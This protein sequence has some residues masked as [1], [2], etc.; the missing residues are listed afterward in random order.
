MCEDQNT[1]KRLI[2]HWLNF[3]IWSITYTSDKPETINSVSRENI[4]HYGQHLKSEFENGKFTRTNT[5]ASYLSGMNSVMELIHGD[6]W[7]KISLLKDCGSESIS[8]IP[9]K[10]PK[11]DKK[12]FP[13]TESLAGYLLGNGLSAPRMHLT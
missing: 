3:C 13:D 2:C 10:K 12:G 11:L 6:N 8:H 1:Q 4:I 9:N 5:V 7:E